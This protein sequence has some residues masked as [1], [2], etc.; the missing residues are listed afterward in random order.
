MKVLAVDDDP[1]IIEA[2]GICFAL[3]WPEAELIQ[4]PDGN[5]ALARFEDEQPD[6]VILDIGLPDISGLQVC[7]SLRE[8]SEVP[9][10][11]LTARDSELDMVRGLESGADDYVTKPFSHIELMA[12]IRAVLRRASVGTVGS[13]EGA[14]EQGPFKFDFAD[15]SVFY[16]GQKVPLTPTEY[17]LLYHLT[18]NYPNVVQH[19]TLLAKVWGRE[20]IDETEYLK[21]HVQRIRSKF[22]SLAENSDPIENE[23]GVGYRLNLSQTVE[24]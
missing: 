9:I 2:V 21:V 18:K 16:D 23:R 13:T 11:M 20:Y 15:H 7:A 10:I 6:V 14:F 3:R 19:R 17:N 1:D 5:T 24:A 4:A 12:R 8:H 22:E